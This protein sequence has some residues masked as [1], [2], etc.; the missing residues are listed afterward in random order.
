MSAPR[1]TKKVWVGEARVTFTDPERTLLDGLMMP[2][3]DPKEP[4][5]QGTVMKLLR[6][7]LQEARKQLGVPWEVIERDYLLSWILAG[8]S[9]VGPLRDTLVFKGGTALKKSGF[10]SG[11]P[12]KTGTL[13]P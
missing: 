4:P 10:S 12:Q 5:R 9:R 7:R 6:A 2:L 3:D 11:S 8:I 1:K 13:T